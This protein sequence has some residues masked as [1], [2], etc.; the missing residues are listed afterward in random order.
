VATLVVSPEQELD[1]PLN[2]QPE[3]PELPASSSANGKA[4][5]I[6]NAVVLGMLF[7]APALM[8][9]HAACA[10]D[11]DIWWHLRTGEWMLQHHAIPRASA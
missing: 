4:E 5:R 1:A 2:S 7:A 8:C 9:V 6:A 10:N 11:P 3:P